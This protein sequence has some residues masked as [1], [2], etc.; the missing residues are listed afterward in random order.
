MG[1]KKSSSSSNSTT[2]T[3]NIDRRQ[4]VA[5]GATGI[6]ADGATI[7]IE[8]LDA[9]IVQAA[10]DVVKADDATNGAGFEKLLTLADKLFT[11]AGQVIETAQETTLSQIEAIN[12]AANDKKGAIDQKTLIIV[13]GAAIGLMALR[14]K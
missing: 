8:S 7:N 6:A 11:G 12:T 9:G 10:L 4:V 13:A 14:K 5:E 2:T 3:T 1:S